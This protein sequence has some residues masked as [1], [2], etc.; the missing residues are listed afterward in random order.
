MHHT[1]PDKLRALANFLES[2]PGIPVNNWDYPTITVYAGNG[3]EFADAVKA[4]GSGDKRRNNDIMYFTHSEV[5]STEEANRIFTVTAV[6][7]GVCEKKATGKTQ[8]RRV[9][10]PVDARQDEDG[11]WYVEDQVFDYEC[12]PI[13][14]LGED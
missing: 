5:D 11:N 8:R 12:P 13:L 3:K 9:F 1:Y 10:M 14:S 2:H 7:S 6:V 4:M